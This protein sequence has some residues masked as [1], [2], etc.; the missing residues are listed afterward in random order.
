MNG[1]MNKRLGIAEMSPQSQ[2]L[3]T[4]FFFLRSSQT[5]QLQI[6]STYL[7]LFLLDIITYTEL[8]LL[9]AVQ[10]GLTALLDY[11]TGALG[12]AIGHKNVL[13]L[14]YC[15]YAISILFLLASNSLIGLIPFAVLTAV[16]AS[17]ESGALRSWFDNNYRYASENFDDD[18]KIFGAFLGKMQANFFLISGILF[19]VG[20]VLA[21]TYSRRILFIVQLFLILIALGL[22]ILLMKNEDGIEAPQ[23]SFRA[24][25]DRLTGGIQFVSSSRGKL[26]FF[27]GLAVLAAVMISIWGSLMLFPFYESYSGTDEYTGLLRAILFATGV[28]WMLY[29]AN[30]SKR[31]ENPHRGLFLS[32]FM[33]NLFF[34]VLVF[35]FIHL[36]PPPNAFILASFVGVIILFQFLGLS[37]SLVGVLQGRLMIEL[38]PDK[39]RNAVYSLIPTLNLIFSIPLVILGGFVITHYG[40]S[41]GL[42]LAIALE[43]LGILVFGLGLCWLSKPEVPTIEEID[44]APQERPTPTSG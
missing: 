5:A 14:A 18:R 11:P 44:S 17:Q 27:L 39:Y 34:H 22:I 15:F 25:L 30:L 31:I 23:P 36:F 41:D 3:A 21:A 26:F 20:G 4:R 6:A 35:G 42:L 16:A 29:G 19:V 8:G 24:Y 12:D 2:S 9:L 7:I 28:I 43:L 13:I 32:M 38:V 33:S 37:V 10:F 40:F 1:W